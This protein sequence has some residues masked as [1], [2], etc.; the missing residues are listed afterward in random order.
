MAPRRRW[1]TD[2]E[3]WLRGEPIVARRTTTLERAVKWTRR[4]PAVAAL[5]LLV[6]LS[7][8]AGLAG[9]VQQWQRAEAAL[10]EADDR[11]AAEKEARQQADLAREQE[12]AQRRKAEAERGRAE[13]MQLVAQSELMRPTNPG[14]SLLL[15]IE[16]SKRHRS[17]LGNNALYAALDTCR[18]ERVLLGH[19]GTVHSAAFSHDGRRILT[20]GADKTAR[21]WDADTGK[22]ASRA[23]GRE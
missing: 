3:R 1:R 17:L 13:G 7:S 6:I 20:C 9:V 11:A 4:R 15:A 23:A 12:A 8:A 14:L 10:R 18:E 19:A 5:I 2:L 21:L 22:G 16:G